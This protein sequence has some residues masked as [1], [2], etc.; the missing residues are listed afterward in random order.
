M[1]QAAFGS[2]PTPNP[3]CSFR[4][5]HHH[6]LR[7]RRRFF[8]FLAFFVSP[9]TQLAGTVGHSSER[10]RGRERDRQKSERRRVGTRCLGRRLP[11]GLVAS[12]PLENGS[13]RF[14]VEVAQL[15]HRTAHHQRRPTL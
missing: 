11:T 9:L 15:E 5:H 1:G 12:K 4:L 7:R 10:E 2:S 6:H 3:S 14:D 13:R 8:F